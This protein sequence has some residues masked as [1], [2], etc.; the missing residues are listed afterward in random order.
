[1]FFLPICHIICSLLLFSYLLVL[2]SLSLYSSSFP[3]SSSALIFLLV[4]MVMTYLLVLSSSHFPLLTYFS[5]FQF[6]I[7][8]PVVAFFLLLDF[9]SSSWLS[10]YFLYIL[11]MWQGSFR[12][13]PYASSSA[14]WAWFTQFRSAFMPQPLP[15]ASMLGLFT[16]DFFSLNRPLGRFSQ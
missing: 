12:F 9:F 8:K 14:P 10:I 16:S 3:F 1:M 4:I 11:Y 5:I 15:F 2:I 6:H 7:F 13:L